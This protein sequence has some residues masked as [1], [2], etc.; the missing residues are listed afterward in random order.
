MGL[1]VAA[2]V[3]IL[4][5][6]LGGFLLASRGG[7]K[8]EDKKSD[9]T[10]TAQ[11]PSFDK[12]KFSLSDPT[13]PWLVVN[14]KRALDP[15]RYAPADLTAPN[16]ELAGADS[17]DN[18]RVNAATAAALTELNTAAIAEDIQLVLVSGYRSYDTQVTVYNSEVKGFGQAQADRESARPG[19]SEHQTGW[20]A[21]LAAA[22]GKCKI[23]ACFADTPEGK[24]LAANAHKHGFVIRYAKNKEHVTGYNFEP[25]HL[26]FVGKELAA[27]MYTKN[28]ATLEEFFS[29]P[30][31]PGY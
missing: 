17:A 1:F 20:A 4:I 31:A 18:M 23:E 16:M 10:N 7:N 13:S 14:K 30:A 6:A 5:I 8:G 29:L 22:N 11:E 21:D 26:R 25:W 24:W 12:K 27:E 3:L 28:I 15:I 19:H 2:G 9:T